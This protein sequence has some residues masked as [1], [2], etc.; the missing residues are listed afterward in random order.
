M[1]QLN[2][3]K[4]SVLVSV[5]VLIL[6]A[7]G[8]KKFLWLSLPPS[9]V[10]KDCSFTNSENED[11]ESRLVGEIPKIELSNL[12]GVLISQ[13]GGVINDASCLN[14]TPILG[15]V[16]VKSEV[17]LGKVLAFANA[18][19]LKVTVAGEKHSMGGQ[20]FSRNGLIV[21][22]DKMSE[23]SY[24]N[25]TGTFK[26][27][28]GA[29][30]AEVERYLDGLGKSLKAVQSINIFSVGGT[31]SVNAHGI[32]H[33]PGPIAETIKSLRVMLANGEIKQISPQTDPEL[34][35]LIVGGYGLFGIILEAELEVMN[36]EVYTWTTD[37]MNYTDFASFYEKNVKGNPNLGLFYSRISVSPSSYLT[38][39]AAHSFTKVQNYN[40]SIPVI[41][42]SNLDWAN[43]FVI[44]FSKTGSFG[45]WV[46]WSLEKYLEPK[47]HYCIS[48]NQLLNDK[49][50]CLVS[51]NH[52]MYDSMGYLKNRLKDTDILQEYFVRPENMA[53]FV[54][55]L[56]ETVQKNDVNLLNVTIR[57]VEKDDVSYLAYAKED[58]FAFVLY[59]NQKLNSEDS[60]KLSKATNELIDLAMKLDGSFYLPYQLT[61]SKDQLQ[62]V[63]PQID[64][65]FEF[66]NKYDPNEVFVNKFYLKYKGE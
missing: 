11:K 41:E 46:R 27:Q 8:V 18:N 31:I 52:E 4:K 43:R 21:N 12:E 35:S 16:E 13:E 60:A 10:P 23:M 54:D 6:V 56:R 62:G 50:V 15:V 34:F 3:I 58:M 38:E 53:D 55:G 36:N 47:I 1:K 65:F 9:D 17:D 61:Y 59:F 63:Y 40:E 25:E 32:A 22:M 19:S 29:R 28:A 66:K 7:V 14:Q 2:K 48:R 5:L 33:S 42:E 24:S 44:N 57:I 37:Y 30:W 45:R 49:E 26:V 20:A 64:S 39:V 51:R